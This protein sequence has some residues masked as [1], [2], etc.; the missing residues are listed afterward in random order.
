MCSLPSTRV[1]RKS[2]TSPLA[3]VPSS[4]LRGCPCAPP[5]GTERNRAAED[6]IHKLEA[7][8]PSGRLDLDVTDRVLPVAA[9]L[10]HK[11][12]FR[13]GGSRDRLLVGH[14]NRHGLHVRAELALHAL[15]GDVDVR[16]GQ[17]PR[18]ES[19]P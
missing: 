8:T 14:F 12:A 2:T 18:T 9:G 11:A 15:Q 19:V 6:L 16:L 3:S 5:R 17:C 1:T 13:R 4:W 7:F 10:A